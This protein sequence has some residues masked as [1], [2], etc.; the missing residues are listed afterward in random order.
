MFWRTKKAGRIKIKKD[1]LMERLG[2]KK[3]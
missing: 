2:L 3:D 1:G